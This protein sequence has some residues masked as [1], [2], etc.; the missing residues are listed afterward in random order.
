MDQSIHRK[1]ASMTKLHYS[2]YQIY[3]VLEH[4]GQISGLMFSTVETVKVINSKRVTVSLKGENNQSTV[5]NFSTTEAK[6]SVTPCKLEV[7]QIE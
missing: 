2:S 3:A 7:S 5:L 6:C 4:L 1:P